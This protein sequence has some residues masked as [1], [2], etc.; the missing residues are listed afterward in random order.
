MKGSSFDEAFL[1]RA[2]LFAALSPGAR[3]DLRPPPM[4]SCSGQETASGRLPAR[5]RVAVF[6]EALLRALLKKKS[7]AVTALAGDLG[8]EVTRL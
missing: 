3:A 8:A 4:W 2:A 1:L 7:G 6:P 5:A